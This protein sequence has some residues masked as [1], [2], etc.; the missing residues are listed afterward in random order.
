MYLYRVFLNLTDRFRGVIVGIKIM[1]H[2]H[3]TW[4]HKPRLV[5]EN[6]KSCRQDSEPDEESG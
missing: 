4:D 6:R 1:K 5:G 3:R 2:C